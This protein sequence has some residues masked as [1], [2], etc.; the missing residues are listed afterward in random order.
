MSL[1]ELIHRYSPERTREEKLHILDALASHLPAPAFLWLGVAAE[2]LKDED[3]SLRQAALHLLSHAPQGW[4][5]VLVSA[6]TSADEA[7]QQACL[8]VLASMAFSSAK[9]QEAF[10]A[11]GDLPGWL[12]GALATWEAAREQF[13]PAAEDAEVCEPE[14]AAE[15][16]HDVIEALQAEKAALSE[17]LAGQKL[18]AE[19]RSAELEVLQ[20]RLREEMEALKQSL[21]VSQQERQAL[22]ESVQETLHTYQQRQSRL[23]AAC[24]AAA[25]LAVA[26]VPAGWALG[27]RAAVS[28]AVPEYDYSA[29]TT[30]VQLPAAAGEPAADAEP[31][32]PAVTEPEPQ[33]LKEAED[34]GYRRAMQAMA[35]RAVDLEKQGLWRPA[36]AIWQTYGRLATNPSEAKL[37]REKSDALLKKLAPAARP[38]VKPPRAHTVHRAPVIKAVPVPPAKL[39][40]PPAPPSPDPLEE[41]IPE[42]IRS[43]F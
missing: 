7:H 24:I 4:D 32:P 13:P 9:L 27:S 20:G 30:P 15:A 1:N 10:H 25:V 17:A 2:A 23:V 8:Q 3:A 37:G 21:D 40:A 42:D 28:A 5:L 29:I 22:A 26:G 43:K 36:A 18:E 19:A 31:A 38:Q 14:P 6:L 39:P 41:A 11:L 12:P 34:T 16:A 35:S 33:A